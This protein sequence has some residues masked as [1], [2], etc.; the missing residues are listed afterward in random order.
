MLK[1]AVERIETP[2]AIRYPRGS[3]G[4]YTS[5]SAGHMVSVFGEGEEAAI[6]AYGDMVN[7][8]L[9][10]TDVLH[11]HGID[12]RV[13]KINV[14]NPL[15]I[16]AVLSACANCPAV[17]VAEDVCAHGCVGKDILAARHEGVRIKNLGSGIVP[18]GSVGELL[19][20]YGLDGQGI[21]DTILE[22]LGE[23]QNGEDATGSADL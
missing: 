18:H 21:A 17:V 16:D 23:E 11:T 1:I 15:D 2:V 6:I 3:E 7:Q 10:A 9:E 20:N 13:V 5:N 12:A 19:K 22:M 8:A 14:I 4:R